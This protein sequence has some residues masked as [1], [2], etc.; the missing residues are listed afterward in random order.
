MHAVDISGQVAGFSEEILVENLVDSM[1]QEGDQSEEDER[2][3]K[4]KSKR[5]TKQ[6]R[7]QA[8]ASDRHVAAAAELERIRKVPQSATSNGLAGVGEN[9]ESTSNEETDGRA[10][11]INSTV[12]EPKHAK[13]AFRGKKIKKDKVMSGDD[14]GRESA[15]GPHL[16]FWFYQLLN[17]Y[18]NLTSAV[19]LDPLPSTFFL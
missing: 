17:A 6:E 3:R 12:K 1:M 18:S 9:P 5:R 19:G 4:G 16:L 13:L 7:N 10:D 11:V 15:S 8:A 14:R 2:P